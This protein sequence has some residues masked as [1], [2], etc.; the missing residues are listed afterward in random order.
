MVYKAQRSAT[1]TLFWHDYETMG[2][3]KA[4]DRPLQ[5][6]G[7][8]TDLNLNPIGEP[9]ALFCRVAEDVVPDPT[10]CLLTGITPQRCER[11]GA[12]NEAEFARRIQ[13]ELGKP[14]TCGV[15]FNT[16]R[17][18][19][20]VTRNLLFRTLQDPYE[21][22]WANGNSRWDIID[23]VRAVYALRPSL[24]KWPT[25][26]EGKVSFRLEKLADANG[27]VKT[28]AHDA[29]SDVETTIALARL[30]KER[31]P[32]LFHHYFEQRLKRNVASR[33]NMTDQTPLFHVSSLHG[34]DRHCLAPVMPLAVHPTMA[35]VYIVFDLNADPSELLSLPASEIADRV[36][37]AE[38]GQR[39]PLTTIYT[40]KSPFLML[41][42][43][44]KALGVESLGAGF[45]KQKCSEHWKLLRSRAQEVGRK[46][47]EVYANNENS[48]IGGDPELS[49]YSGFASNT[50]KAK[51][52]RIAASSPEQLA[53]A[54]DWGFDNPMYNELLFRHR[55]R[56]WPESL[57]E[58]EQKQWNAF[59]TDRI[60]SGGPMKGR[61]MTDFKRIIEDLRADPATATNPLLDEMEQW[62]GLPPPSFVRRLPESC[63]LTISS[64]FK[65]RPPLPAGS[66]HGNC[67][68]PWV[69]RTYCSRRPW[70]VRNQI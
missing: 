9:V 54:G 28:R 5:F 21:R 3:H 24:M 37:R 1:P 36:F 4:L 29:V 58:E 18:D 14:G 55:A 23:L 62:P 19:D 35:N 56:N 38:K 11:E 49:I 52:V 47:Q 53:A 48:Y 45:D 64:M 20:E 12:V 66:G 70:C 8:R 31:A 2:L 50:D 60:H 26:D 32:E 68:S 34:L 30:I 39:L 15:G 16:I 33:F 40:N 17:F 41:P 59:V 10:A 7:I 6:A 44:L 43:E 22:E 69:A 27:L 13:E 63:F 57:S 25:D 51:F 67:N 65:D 61:T 42:T 46:V